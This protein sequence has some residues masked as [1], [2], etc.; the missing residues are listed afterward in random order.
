MHQTLVL[1]IALV[2]A[3]W[4]SYQ[5]RGHDINM[6]SVMKPHA[7]GSVNLHFILDIIHDLDK[8]LSGKIAVVVGATSG[9]GEGCALRLAEAG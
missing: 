9:I 5:D 1:T 2:A 3:Y 7:Q 6:A 4:V 8:P